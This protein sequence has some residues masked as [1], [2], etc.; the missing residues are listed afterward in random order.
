MCLL[1]AETCDQPGVHLPDAGN[2]ELKARCSNVSDSL[3]DTKSRDP[4]A[5][6]VGGDGN[7]LKAQDDGM[8]LE[9]E[10][11]FTTSNVRPVPVSRTAHP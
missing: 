7:E 3:L 11:P 8:S 1:D 10:L 2:N 6:V 5:S 4:C 9:V